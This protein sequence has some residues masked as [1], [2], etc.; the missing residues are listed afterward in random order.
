MR[1]ITHETLGEAS[2]FGANGAMDALRTRN[3]S[4]E[5]LAKAAPDTAKDA[6][7]AGRPTR[8]QAQARHLALLDT[9]LTHFLAKGYEAATIDAIAADV[10]MTKRTVYARYPD[11]AALFRAALRHGTERRAVSREVIAGTRRATL[12]ET[13]VAVARLRIALI[14][15]P[16][17]AA[18]YRLISTESYRFPDITRTYYEVAAQPTVEFLAAILAEETRAGQ[19]AIERPT[20][21]ATTFM[22]MVVGGPVHFIMSGN[23][24]GD[25]E[26]EER[27]RFAVRL[28]LKGAQVR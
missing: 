22:S 23:D 14:E 25:D 6:V 1:F 24:L 12:E 18:L 9:S 4:A 2:G 28:F 11:K 20:L 13:L 26:I 5:S 17:G 8:E 7:R 21:A 19:L 15:D 10:N 16:A 3:L 27:V